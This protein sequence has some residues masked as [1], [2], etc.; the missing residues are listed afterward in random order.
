MLAY[1]FWHW[2]RPQVSEQDY[3]EHL[4]RFHRAL[5]AEPPRGFISSAAFRVDGARWI[6]QPR[7]YEDW[8]LVDDFA[9]LGTLNE[10]A[11]SASRKLPHD[12]VARLAA[13]GTAGVYRLVGGEA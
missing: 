1:V 5:A 9:A 13:D 12:E 11:V 2:H 10:A 3:E 6:P 7:T 8:Y 4:R